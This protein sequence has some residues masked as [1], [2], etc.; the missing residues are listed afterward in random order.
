MRESVV[1]GEGATAIRQ[2]DTGVHFDSEWKE[3]FSVFMAQQ[4]T[5]TPAFRDMTSANYRAMREEYLRIGFSDVDRARHLL[6]NY[7]EQTGDTSHP[8]VTAESLVEAV[9]GGRVSVTVEEGPFLKHMVDQIEFLARWI[10][11]FDWE[12]LRASV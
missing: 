4:I 10:V 1:D 3:S 7:R 11:T 12:I 8:D 9:I 6:E 2:L 5:R